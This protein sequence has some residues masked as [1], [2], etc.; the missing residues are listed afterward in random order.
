MKTR[1]LSDVEQVLGDPVNT[2]HTL[3]KRP[4]ILEIGCGVGNALLDLKKIF[5]QSLLIGMNFCPCDEKTGPSYI[6]GDAGICVPL[7]AGSV[8]FIYSIHT[9]Q[10][11]RDKARLLSECHRILRIGGEMRIYIPPLLKGVPTNLANPCSIQYKEQSISLTDFLVGYYPAEFSV[12][13]VREHSVLCLK[14]KYPDMQLD[15]VLVDADLDYGCFNPNYS[16][17]VRSLYIFNTNAKMP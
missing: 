9:V 11:I 15:L 14:K 10:F 13:K 3:S 7:A 5:P 16:R 6:H 12:I 1:G 2:I 17:Y 4:T 8:D